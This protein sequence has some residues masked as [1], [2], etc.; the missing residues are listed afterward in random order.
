MTFP[1]PLGKTST[2]IAGHRVSAAYDKDA[3]VNAARAIVDLLELDRVPREEMSRMP[4]FGD[5]RSGSHYN[6][7]LRAERRSGRSHKYGG[8]S[9]R[10]GGAVA[11]MMAA[12]PTRDG[13]VGVRLLHPPPNSGKRSDAQVAEMHREGRGSKPPRLWP[14]GR[15]AKPGDPPRGGNGGS[16]RGLAR[17]SLS[18][19][20]G[21]AHALF[22]PKG[23]GLALG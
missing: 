20:L 7:S 1:P 6:G 4:L 3:P 9:Y 14:S 18:Q 13:A 10:I 15:G 5:P 2:D 21:D 22:H 11:L 8:H 17:A 23:W 16:D 19:R 12:N